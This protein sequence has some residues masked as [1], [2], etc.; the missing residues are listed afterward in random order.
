MG[1]DGQTFEGEEG[2]KLEVG[3]YAQEEMN[4]L[5]KII[6]EIAT[7]FR[8]D[9]SRSTLFELV[10]P[11]LAAILLYAQNT[12]LLEKDLRSYI[13]AVFLGWAFLAMFGFFI[14]IIREIWVIGLPNTPTPGPGVPVRLQMESRGGFIAGRKIRIVADVISLEL[15]KGLES[16]GEFKKIYKNIDIAFMDSIAV[17]ITDGKILKGS[18]EAGGVRLTPEKMKASKTIVFNSPGTFNPMIFFDKQNDP[19]HYGGPMPENLLNRK[20]TVS[21]AES[22]V[23]LRN[24][25]ITYS[26][27]LVILLL[28]L[29]QLNLV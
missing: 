4:I 15:G 29:V 26:L 28:T 16:H 23:G 13:V 20:L 7:F 1:F 25:A 8:Y 9:L 22:W 21:P 24:Y 12:N 6:A 17:P 2:S 19:Q 27:T 10:F 5:K 3:S 14:P 11:V 18:P